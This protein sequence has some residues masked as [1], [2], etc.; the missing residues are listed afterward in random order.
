[1]TVV[2]SR[3]DREA[4]GREVWLERAAAV[5]K[6]GSFEERLV[7][8]V[9]GIRVEP[10]YGRIDAPRA[11]R[12][13]EDP[14]IVHQRCDHPDA[15]RANAQAL[16]DL[17]GGATGLTLAFRGHAAAR[18]FG[19]DTARLAQ[20]LEG[21]ELH[22]IALRVEGPAE[23]ARNVASF[24]A[25]RPLDPARLDISFGLGDPSEARN[26]IAQGFRGAIMEADGRPV[27]EQGG[28]D[29]DELAFV[30]YEAV[31]HLRALEAAYTGVTLAAHQDMFMTL[32]KFRAMRLLWRRVTEHA[33]LPDAALRI[34]GETSFRMLAAR[35][36]HTNILRAC[37]A[38]FGAG[39]GG[40]DSIAVLPFSI[41]QGLPNGFARRV[42]RNVQTVMLAEAHLWRVLDPASGAGYV[43]HLTEE[44]C[45][46]AWE[47]FRT[48]EAAG[49]PSSFTA[50]PLRHLPVIGT[51]VYP[52]PKEY[53]A[54]IE[55][56]S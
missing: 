14:W 4:A 30:L 49:V 27:H 15:A 24:I 44:L 52:L 38:V 17:A 51:S 25:T 22:A 7:R 16:D 13:H 6:G 1:M 11:E 42:A 39:L 23:A 34:H 53:P 21:V 32:A 54:E 31:R 55:A 2:V 43:E 41:V 50:D 56:A 33:G 45:G 10:L 46:R 26:V 3:A 40:A 28:S 20:V 12:A 19:I 29:A 9:D 35:D 5:L 48:A 18:G 47:L 37:A 8:T 36:P